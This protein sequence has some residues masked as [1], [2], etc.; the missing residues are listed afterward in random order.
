MTDAPNKPKRKILLL[1]KLRTD[2]S[3]FREIVKPITCTLMKLRKSFAIMIRSHPLPLIGGSVMQ[4][5]LFDTQKRFIIN[6]TNLLGI[7]QLFRTSSRF[8]IHELALKFL[9]P[10]GFKSTSHN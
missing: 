10:L 7:H 2:H 1:A 6:W 8:Y 3:K 9:L 4:N 5:S